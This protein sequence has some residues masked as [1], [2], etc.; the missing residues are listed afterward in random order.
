MQANIV[1]AVNKVIRIAQE[2]QF[3][4]MEGPQQLYEDSLEDLENAK[5]DLLKIIDDYAPTKD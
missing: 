5:S 4:R 3:Q 1:E 2:V